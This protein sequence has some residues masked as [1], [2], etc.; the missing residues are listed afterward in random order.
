MWPDLVCSA[1][2]SSR[3]GFSHRRER[4]TSSIDKHSS[5]ADPSAEFARA[6]QVLGVVRFAASIALCKSAALPLIAI[7]LVSGPG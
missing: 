6:C 4:Q 1:D 7:A 5:C 3:S 2:A